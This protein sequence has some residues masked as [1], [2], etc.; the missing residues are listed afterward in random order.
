ME[1]AA[2][3][4]QQNLCVVASI[5]F[6]CKSVVLGA[7]FLAGVAATAHAP[8][9][10]AEWS[11]HERLIISPGS[12]R[13]FDVVQL[14]GGRCGPFRQH[15]G[16]RQDRGKQQLRRCRG[17]EGLSGRS[18]RTYP[19]CR[20]WCASA[21]KDPVTAKS[22]AY[23]DHSPERLLLNP[24]DTIVFGGDDLPRDSGESSCR[25]GCRFRSDASPAPQQ[26][27]SASYEWF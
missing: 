22:P 2:Q 20:S 4:N 1:R 11:L 18:S 24:S 5:G 10:S 15:P 23:H 6:L 13:L 25:G 3:N 8:S 12:N 19:S 9:A 26:P 14:L 7:A 17:P 27:A 21:P 16:L